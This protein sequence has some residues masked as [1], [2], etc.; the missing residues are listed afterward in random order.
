MDFAGLAQARIELTCLRVGTAMVLQGLVALAVLALIGMVSW[1][2][3][4]LGLSVA[5]ATALLLV[6]LLKI[7]GEAPR[8]Y[9]AMALVGLC[10]AGV[11]LVVKGLSLLR[12]SAA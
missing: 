12:K 1:R 7:A 6:F 4:R 3:P 8:P 2:W 9:L 11:V 5:A 10:L